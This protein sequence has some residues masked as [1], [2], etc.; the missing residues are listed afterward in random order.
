MTPEP[1]DHH[2]GGRCGPNA[3]QDL[4]LSAGHAARSSPRIS[5]VSVPAGTSRTLE[6]VGPSHGNPFG[7]VPRARHDWTSPPRSNGCGLG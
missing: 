4:H 3:V 1:H 2:P 5:S 7:R 6:I